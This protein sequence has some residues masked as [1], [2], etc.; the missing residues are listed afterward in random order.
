MTELRIQLAGIHDKPVIANLLQY[1]LY[2]FSEFDDTEME[3]DGTFTYPYLNHYWREPDRSPYVFF[4]GDVPAG[5]ALVRKDSDPR[6]GEL[7]S[8]LAEFFILRSL[9]RRRFG[10]VAATGLWN[11]IG[12]AW[13]VRVLKSNLVAYKFWR[14]L[15]ASYTEDQFREEMIDDEY[16]FRFSI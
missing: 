14:P 2:D 16:N 1:Y 9:R 3:S 4:L 15:I 12:G 7:F 11:H 10:T 13:Q 5:F 6:S 8:D